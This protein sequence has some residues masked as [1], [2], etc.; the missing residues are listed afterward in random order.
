M[1]VF[2]Q[3]RSRVI[4][5]LFGVVF[6]I[7]A[8]QLVNLQV[9]SKKYKLQAENNAIYRK[10]IYPD[11]GII[12]DRKKRSLL[13]NSIMFDLVVTPSEARGIDTLAL[14]NLLEIDTAEYKK[15]MRDIIFKNTS[16]RP[17]VFEPL[18]S[19]ELYARLSENIYK[20]P[21]FE[22]SERSV[23]SYPLHIGANFLGYT[24]EVNPA[25]LAKHKDEGYEMGDYT[26]MTGL[27]RTY[28]KVLM[29][30]RGIKR[31]IKDNRS[32]IQGS[33][34]NGLFDT[35]AIAGKN[36]YL[37]LD[38][39]LQ[40]LGEKL[41]T[42]KVG[43]I[44]AIDPKTGGILCMVSA[45]SYDPNYLTGSERSK[46]FNKLYKDP[47]LPL[48]N[49]AIYTTYSPGSTFK[50]VVGIIG[51]SE[52]VINERFSVVCNGA[53]WG[54][55]NGRPKCLDKGTFNLTTAIAHSDNTYFATVYKRILDQPRYGGA[56]SALKVFNT[57]AYTF[58][59]GH[60]LGIDLP[61]EQPG[62]L[63]VSSYYRKIFG[64]N[65]N[66][67]NVISNAIGQGEVSTTVLQLANVMATIANKGWYYTPH[68]VDSIEGNEF[69]D[70]LVRFKE[71]HFTD[72]EI[73]DSV[74]DAVQ[75]G[76][77]GV[78]EYGTGAAA[79]VPGIVVCGKTG[80]VQNYYH[81]VAQ[82]DHAFFGAFAPRN[83]PKIA[84]AVLCE[85]AGFGAQSAAPIASLMIEQYL[86]DSIPEPDRKQKVEEIA[87]LNLIP[88]RMRAE[89]NRLDSIKM[90]KEEE[91]QNRQNIQEQILDSTSAETTMV[92]QPIVEPTQKPQSPQELPD[93]HPKS[94]MANLITTEHKKKKIT[95]I[96]A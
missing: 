32:R 54:C 63:P 74:Y 4:Q 17:S 31:Y 84:I 14:C 92:T 70:L 68:M 37:S 1:P 95:D 20:F 86:K 35:A 43:S 71:K 72:R 13:E 53:F 15:R 38:A 44:V 91:E 28:E 64:K 89:M 12:F 2:N 73:P 85:N 75:N 65:W 81:G 69:D 49:R 61:G 33:Y 16:V 26:G 94:W 59:L 3:S 39:Q 55:G 24:A 51:L 66:S 7:I 45:P 22:L 76:M 96:N 93:N 41:M 48:L 78:M 87:K 25:F 46:H 40:A 9:F 57:Y 29:G 80:T 5:I 62:N 67:C 11:R 36:L 30:Q 18:L 77:Q 21:G 79:Q 8:A 60:K 19:Q 47:R 83:N 56:D 50:T 52:G 58:G 82:K 10:V 6:I 88:A 34:E 23:R 27:E 90:K 42:N